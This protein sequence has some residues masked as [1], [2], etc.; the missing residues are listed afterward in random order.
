MVSEAGLPVTGGWGS[1]PYRPEQDNALIYEFIL[2]V[3]GKKIALNMICFSEF[4]NFLSSSLSYKSNTFSDT[5]TLVT[6]MTNHHS[7]VF[8]L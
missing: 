3:T 2:L 1:S 4:A 5:S 6:S 8:P 7:I